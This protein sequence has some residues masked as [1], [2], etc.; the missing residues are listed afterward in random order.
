MKIRLWTTSRVSH[1]EDRI[2]PHCWSNRE[3]PAYKVFEKTRETVKKCGVTGPLME[4]I[5]VTER[6]A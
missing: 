2:L 6:E 1:K 3:N 5:L 4:D